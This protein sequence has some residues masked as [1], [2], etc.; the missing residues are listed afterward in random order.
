MQSY[1]KKYWLLLIA[2]ILILTFAA[3]ESPTGA[4]GAT[5]FI[6][7]NGNWWIGAKDTGVPATGPAGDPGPEGSIGPAG[8]AGPEGPIGHEGPIGPAGVSSGKLYDGN[9]V[10]LGYCNFIEYDKIIV[11]SP[12]GYM[13]QLTWNG[14]FDQRVGNVALWFTGLNG[15]GSV[16]LV[17][18]PVFIGNGLAIYSYNNLL[19]TFSDLDALGIPEYEIL[20]PAFQSMLEYSKNEAVDNISYPPSFSAN[21]R[22]YLLKTI[23]RADA[24]IPDTIA[25]P[26]RFSVE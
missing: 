3:C 17:R 1:T 21:Y 2:F 24:G 12:N 4:S 7:E 26:L 8:D 14:E 11:F 9:D 10:L 19:Y 16:Y 22:A 13:Y 5:P 25:L 23:T 15:T 18:D 20:I 6:G